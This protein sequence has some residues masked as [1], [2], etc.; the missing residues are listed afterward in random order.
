M[1]AR[2]TT[3][4]HNTICTVQSL[5]GGRGL[6][7]STTT[8]IDN[9]KFDNRIAKKEKTWQPDMGRGSR[10]Q[11]DRAFCLF[12]SSGVG[13]AAQGIDGGHGDNKYLT[14]LCIRTGRG[15]TGRGATRDWAQGATARYDT[16]RYGIFRY[17]LQ[18]AED[19][20]SSSLPL[21]RYEAEWICWAE[22]E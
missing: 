5:P 16:V 14:Y 4:H 6:A 15:S 1:L 17:T 21:I 2:A 9:K 18:R 20:V 7:S 12:S 11:G 19:L 13:G 3:Y 10:W 22:R 8:S